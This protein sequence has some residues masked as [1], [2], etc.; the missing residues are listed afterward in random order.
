VE[1]TLSPALTAFFC[2]RL[3]RALLTPFADRDENKTF[4]IY[5]IYTVVKKKNSGYT[6]TTF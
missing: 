3:F 1:E 2:V 6:I 4:D 5:N